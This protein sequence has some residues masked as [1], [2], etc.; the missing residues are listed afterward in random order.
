MITLNSL[1]LGDSIQLLKEIPLCSID[2]VVSDIPY[3][4]SY[5]D[6]DVLYNNTNSALLGSSP[7][8]EN[9]G[10][11]FKSRGKPLNG[12]SEADKKIP[13]E[14]YK[15]CKSWTDTLF[16]ILKP[17]S[18]VFIFAGRRYAHRAICAFEDSGFIFKDM[19]AWNKIK[20]AH[21]AQHIS[22]VFERRGDFKNAQ[23]W[24]GWKVGNL[25]PIF[26]PILCFMKPYQIGGTI[27]D[28]LLEYN[29]GAYNESIVKLYSQSPNNLISFGSMK[30]DTGLHPAQKP[31]ELMKYLIELVSKEGQ[32]ILDPFAGSGTTLLACK[33]L[34]RNFIGIEKNE[35]FYNL[36]K[37]RINKPLTTQLNFFRKS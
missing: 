2:H 22:K 17:A 18:S 23:K 13:I 34:N 16:N 28:N 32:V 36:A 11:V 29:L 14:Y 21:R 20:S 24:E 19:I 12:W 37:T 7:A 10:K 35:I 33:E 25:R 4:I 1:N 8:Q 5:D 30:S 3:G 26:E 27:A 31:L 9:A 6:W 15:W